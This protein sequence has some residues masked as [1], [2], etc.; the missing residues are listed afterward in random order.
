[1]PTLDYELIMNYINQVKNIRFEQKISYGIIA[2][3]LSIVLLQSVVNINIADANNRSYKISIPPDLKFGA[4]VTTDDINK[5]EVYN[6]AGYVTQQL[7]FWQQNGAV[8]F[9]ANIDKLSAYIT[10]GYRQY[11]LNK[12]TNLQGLGQLKDRDK[13]LSALKQYN[14]KNIKSIDQGTWQVSIDFLAQEHISH[15][16]F[17]NKK[18]RYFISVVIRD[19]NPEFNP[20]GLQL[21]IPFSTPKELK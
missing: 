1:M 9:R 14:E 7:Y 3:L 17:K 5:F 19:V 8:D 13:S 15:Q 21:D 18:L 6:F 2:V 10:P 4:I 11:L 12:Y 20:W 16:R